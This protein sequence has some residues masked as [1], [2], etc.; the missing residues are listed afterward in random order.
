M[1]YQVKAMYGNISPH[2]K[3]NSPKSNVNNASKRPAAWVAPRTN[4]DTT[5]TGTQSIHPSEFRGT[6][7]KL[8]STTTK[9]C[10][11]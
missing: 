1:S 8:I 4:L 5:F 9:T 2:K 7:Q 11:V 10:H 6:L 3:L